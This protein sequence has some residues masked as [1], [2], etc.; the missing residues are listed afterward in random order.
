[1]A[2]VK[3]LNYKE[4]SPEAQAVFDDIKQPATSLMSIIFGKPSPISR[5][6]CNA[7]G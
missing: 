1:M 2:I 7:L 5:K 4:A 3:L 6:I